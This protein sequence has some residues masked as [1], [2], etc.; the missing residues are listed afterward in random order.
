M[1]ISF[2]KH[3]C[4]FCG[5]KGER[6]VTTDFETDKKI[7]FIEKFFQRKLPHGPYRKVI[8][9]CRTGNL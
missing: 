3:Y 6:N 1:H 5:R 7:M 9:M 8:R 2:L 4:Y